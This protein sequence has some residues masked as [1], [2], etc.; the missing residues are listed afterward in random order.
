MKAIGPV[1]S[2]TPLS[3]SVIACAARAESPFDYL[4]QCRNEHDGEIQRYESF[5]HEASCGHGV[6]R[7]CR[8]DD[9]H[10]RCHTRYVSFCRGDVMTVEKDSIVT[11]CQKSTGGHPPFHLYKTSDKCQILHPTWKKSQVLK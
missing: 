1:E 2:A 7:L 10:D 5:E 8:D 3:Q 11:S 4:F 6:R 9:S